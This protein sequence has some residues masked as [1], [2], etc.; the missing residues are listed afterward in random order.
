MQ[1]TRPSK[2]RDLGALLA[3]GAIY[4]LTIWPQTR[5]E[6]KHWRGQARTIP[7]VALRDIALGKLGGEGLNLEGAAFF[8]VVAPRQQRRQRTGLIVAFQVLYDYLDGVNEASPSLDGG[9]RMHRA[10]IDAV[11][12]GAPVGR[13]YDGDDGGY[14]AACVGACRGAVSPHPVLTHAVERVG[15]AQARNHAGPSYL[16]DWSANLAPRTDYRWWELAAAGISCLSIHALFAVGADARLAAVEEAHFPGVCAISALLDSLMDFEDDRRTGNHSFVGWYQSS[17]HAARRF[18]EIL[19]DTD[20]Q[21]RLLPRGRRH[22]VILAGIASYYLSA[23]EVRS[24]FA[25]PVRNRSLGILGVVARPML[26]VMALRRRL[27]GG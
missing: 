15:E 22:A 4:W 2:T 11:T 13:Y 1:P 16:K 25:L 10:L 27:H 9:L 12:P 14:A 24:A 17:A 18:G 7:D 6:L 20:R 19:Q 21:L 8:A 5:R 23:P 3:S 26:T